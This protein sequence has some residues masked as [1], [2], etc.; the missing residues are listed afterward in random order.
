M[1]R[2][3]KARD[4]KGTTNLPDARD[5]RASAEKRSAYRAPAADPA[6]TDHAVTGAE[7]KH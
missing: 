5:P 2:G 6:R 4:H 3:T 1:T 7:K